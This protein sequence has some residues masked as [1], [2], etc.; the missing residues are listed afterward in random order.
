M[1]RTLAVGLLIL[2]FSSNS[3]AWRVGDWKGD[4]P[5]PV[6]VVVE[7]VKHAATQVANG[8]REVTAAVGNATGITNVLDSNRETIFNLGRIQ[9]C[10]YSLC[11]TERIREREIKKAEKEAKEFFER[12]VREA[13]VG[14]DRQKEQDRISNLKAVLSRGQIQL[15]LLNT[16]WEI[17]YNKNEVLKALHKAVKTELNYRKALKDAGI[18]EVPAPSSKNMQKIAQDFSAKVTVEYREALRDVDTEIINLER[19]KGISRADLMAEFFRFL[20]TGALTILQD[21]M[22]ADAKGSQTEYQ[23]VKLSIEAV[24]SD[25]EWAQ[26]ILDKDIK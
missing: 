6:K 11:E 2:A 4:D 15:G 25:L 22:A 23:Q 24:Q 14:Y 26:S 7:G 18:N 20:D 16:R 13:K 5:Q 1:K 10:L 21:N 8:G 12:K 9:A 3:L 17:L 19:A